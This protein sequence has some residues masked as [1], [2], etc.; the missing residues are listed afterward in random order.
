MTHTPKENRYIRAGDPGT[1][2]KLGAAVFVSA[3]E[4]MKH[5]TAD[6]ESSKA[7][8]L[9]QALDAGGM[10]GVAVLVDR[11]RV[12]H[13]ELIALEPD[14]TRHVL[15]VAAADL[16]GYQHAVASAFELIGVIDADLPADMGEAAYRAAQAGARIGVELL[17]KEGG[18]TRAALVAIEHEGARRELACLVNIEPAN[19]TLH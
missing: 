16:R 19:T 17:A 7:A 10:A 14:G 5:M 12:P 18:E 8:L 3:Q 9:N 1:L 13:V 11:H 4:L 6:M 15:A 2:T